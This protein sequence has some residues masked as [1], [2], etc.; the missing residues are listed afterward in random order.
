M[1]VRGRLF[2]A[3]LA[4]CAATRATALLPVPVAF[5]L[6]QGSDRDAAF[7]DGFFYSSSGS[8]LH[9]V[10]VRDPAAGTRCCRGIPG[11]FG[12]VELA[13]PL[14]YLTGPGGSRSWTSRTPRWPQARG[15]LP[16][17]DSARRRVVGARAYLAVSP[18][19]LR[20]ADVSNP[21]APSLLGSLQLESSAPASDADAAVCVEAG[22]AYLLSQSGVDVIDVSDPSAPR[23]IQRIEIGAT[24]SGARSS[25]GWPAL[26]NRLGSVRGTALHLLDV[27]D[28]TAP[29]YLSASGSPEHYFRFALAGDTLY[30]DNASLQVFDVSDS[31]QAEP[32]GVLFTPGNVAPALAQTVELVAGAGAYTWWWPRFTARPGEPAQHG[33]HGAGFPQARA[34]RGGRRLPG[35]PG[36]RRRGRP[37]DRRRAGPPRRERDGASVRAAPLGSVSSRASA[38]VRGRRF[39]RLRG[40]GS[41]LAIVDISSPR[42]PSLR[43]TLP[44]NAA[45]A[46]RAGDVLYV[47]TADGTLEIYTIAD[48]LRPVLLAWLP[49]A[50][51]APADPPLPPSLDPYLIYDFDLAGDVLYAVSL[52]GVRSVDISNR[53]RR[54]DRRVQPARPST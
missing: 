18:L 16:L 27:S 20:I 38:G 30:A 13:A 3:V 31:A 46:T 47:G 28:P 33:R 32:L 8:G 43:G 5:T 42:S 54:V 17:A 36:A 6:D 9:I 11:S 21:A 45:I 51:S 41:A 44:S 1:A 48:R 34:A 25:A 2:V 49:V 37:L 10:D 40:A 50:M 7:S 35:L 39:H 23:V 24:S 52:L 26:L 12:A 29:R 53:R 15:A 4:V 22:V 14:A 19:G